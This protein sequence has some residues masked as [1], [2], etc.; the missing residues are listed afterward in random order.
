M[1]HHVICTIYTAMLGC[2]LVACSDRQSPVEPAMTV[3]A[4]Q[5]GG[6]PT[7]VEPGQVVD[8]ASSAICGFT[9]LVE[10]TG[11][12]KDIALPGG[13]TISI[14]PGDKVTFTNGN[15]GTAVTLN[16]TGP[17]QIN[18]LPDG[19]TEFVFTGNNLVIDTDV[20]FLVATRGRFTIVVG[21][22]GSIV[23]P[24][25]GSGQRTDICALIA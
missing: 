17:F 10:I 1:R 11:K 13:R 21:A 2:A 24:F 20:G 18:P 5:R 12:V 23:Q 19:G 15:T 9:V 22:D 16:G 7:Q 25:E 8:E 3:P 4:L 14:F 6:P